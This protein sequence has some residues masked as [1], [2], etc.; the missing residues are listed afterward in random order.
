M[1][2]LP[3]FLPAQILALA[4]HFCRGS[5]PFNL[6]RVGGCQGALQVTFVHFPTGATLPLPLPVTD[7]HDERGIT[8]RGGQ[9][10]VELVVSQRCDGQPQDGARSHVLPVAVSYTHLT[11]PTTPYV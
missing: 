9:T 8:V 3:H 10:G 4:P 5:N 11:L 2:P 6:P 1:P 7:Q